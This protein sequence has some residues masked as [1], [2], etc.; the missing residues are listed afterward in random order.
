MHFIIR[1]VVIAYNQNLDFRIYCKKNLKQ[2]YN[3]FH[4]NL[5]LQK[6][7]IKDEHLIH[8]R[9]LCFSILLKT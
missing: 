2:Y 5:T 6:I 7:H 8:C 9:S 1:F 4:H 3:S